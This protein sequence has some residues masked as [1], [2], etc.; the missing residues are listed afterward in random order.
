[1]G[2]FFATV[3][4]S[5]VAPATGTVVVPVTVNVFPQPVL[6]VSPTSVTLNHV[7]SVTSPNQ[8]QTIT[9]TTPF[10]T[11]PPN[12]S[13]AFAATTTTP[14]I[15]LGTPTGTTPGTFTISYDLT[16]AG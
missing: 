7:L 6:T 3:T 1:G 10:A 4:L 11:V 5:A 14:W 8:S 12:P 16:K 13:F 9:V 2:A 15:V